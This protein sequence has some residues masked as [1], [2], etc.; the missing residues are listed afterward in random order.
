MRLRDEQNFM[1]HQ[2]E[3]TH[4]YFITLENKVNIFTY[5]KMLVHLIITLKH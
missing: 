3:A 2:F 1:Q 4:E 5:Y